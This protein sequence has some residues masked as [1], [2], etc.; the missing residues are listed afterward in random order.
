MKPKLILFL[1][2][3]GLALFTTSCVLVPEEPGYHHDWG[4]HREHWRD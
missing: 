3:C 1:L 4:W 2:L